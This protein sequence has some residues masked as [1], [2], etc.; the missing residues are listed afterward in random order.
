MRALAA[1]MIRKLFKAS[2]PI[3][4]KKRKTELKTR[5]I[6]FDGN[7]DCVTQ[8]QVRGVTASAFIGNTN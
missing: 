1:T 7:G 3:I 5:Q 6:F 8:F 4:K 2:L